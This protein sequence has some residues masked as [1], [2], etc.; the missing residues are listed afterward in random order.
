MADQLVDA[1][2]A[3]VPRRRQIGTRHRIGHEQDRNDG[4]DPADGAARRFQEDDDEHDADDDVGLGRDGRAIG[5]ILAA[6]EGVDQD[7]DRDGG[8][9]NVEPLDAVAETLRQRKQQEAQHQHERDVGVAQRL[10]RHDREFAEQR[11]NAGDRRV[12]MEQRHPDRDRGDE[13]RGEADEPVR[14]ALLVLDEGFGLAQRLAGDRGAGEAGVDRFRLR[15][16]QFRRLA[17]RVTVLGHV[18]SA[19]LSAPSQGTLPWHRPHGV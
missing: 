3:M 17:V 10:R 15:A 11:R 9:D 8:Q 5:E 14:R 13:R 6:L 12:E 2:A 18:P 16:R 4:N 7:P 1:V 19:L